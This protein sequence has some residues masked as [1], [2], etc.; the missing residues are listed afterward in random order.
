M[1]E[2]G[3]SDRKGEA[4]VLESFLLMRKDKIEAQKTDQL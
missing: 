2:I 4:Y 1:P 3:Q